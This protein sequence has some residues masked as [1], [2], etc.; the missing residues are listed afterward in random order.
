MRK[1]F[2]VLCSVCL[3]SCA[4]LAQVK[5]S[6]QWKCAKA[7]LQHSINV[8]DK[9]GHAYAVDQINCTA[10][11]G[12]IDGVKQKTGLGTEFIEINGDQFTGHGEFVETLANGDKN[13]Y[14]Y[15]MKGTMKNGMLQSASD[16]WS[17][18]EG[19]G[20]LKG[21]KASG[22]CKGG[23]NADQSATWDCSGEYTMA[24]K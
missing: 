10:A 3:L 5:T 6:T 8:G 16:T 24:K 9:P 22:T 11:K 7:A 2:L 21:A 14:T 13:F 12:E 15:Q 17:L 23:G 20:K 18:R 1:L 19:A 4:G